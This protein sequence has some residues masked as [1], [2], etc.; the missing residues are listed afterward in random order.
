ME[1]FQESETLFDTSE[2]IPVYEN[3]GYA[4]IEL[5]GDNNEIIYKNGS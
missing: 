4:T 2:H 5:Y 3:N 1:E